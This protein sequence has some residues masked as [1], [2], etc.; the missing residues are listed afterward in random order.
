MSNLENLKAAKDR[1]ELATLLG[2]KPSAL[3]SII[4]KTPVADKYTTFEIQKK[5]GGIRV[6][7]APNDRLKMLQ[8]RLSDLL[9]KCLAEIEEGRSA[10]PVS[11]GFRKGGKLT[12][13]A[14]NHKR[15]RFVLN[16]DIE[17][18]FPSFNFGRVRGF[19]LRDKS[20]ELN[21]EVATT[22]AQIACDGKAL[23]Q[24]SPC[25][26][27]ISELIGQILDLRLLRFA[28]KHGVR[29]S[30]YADDI[31]F[32]SNQ[33]IFPEALAIQ[34]QENLG[35]WT[36]GKELVDKITA[37]GFSVNDEKTRMHV[38]SSRQMVTGLVVNHKA[39]IKSEYYRNARAMC[40]SLFITGQYFRSLKP[41][42]D[43]GAELLPDMTSSLNPLEGILS[44]IYAVTQSEEGRDDSEQRQSPRAIRKLYRRFLFYK[45]FIAPTAPLIVTEGKTD[46]IYLRAA[47]RRLDKFHPLLGAQGENGF[48]FAIRF[49]NYRGQSHEIMDLGGGSADMKSILL[50]YLQNIDP[51]HKGRKPIAHKPLAHPVIMLV[52][53][54]D[55]LQHIAGPIKKMFKVEITLNSAA[56]FYHIIDNLYLVKTPEA[57]NSSCIE[58]FFPTKW[59]KIELKGKKLSLKT[60][61]DNSKH[62][63]K[64][65][66]AKSVIRPNENDIDFS[67]FEPLLSRIVAVLQDYAA[68]LA[69]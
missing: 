60:K 55:G 33:K 8:A 35:E 3:T 13:N 9:Y 47:I 45:H 24:G 4:Y 62:Y 58:D 16:L 57:G 25:S 27:V 15:R 66:F 21:E 41:G 6:I 5:S 28:K 34:H 36:L 2:Y 65:I 59:K 10:T 49:F 17:D 56:P 7:K 54:D 52:D 69:G 30:R 51:E 14:K 18:F 48:Q 53:N 67:G 39:N 64:E 31:T 50:D 43:D 12:D 42:D 68:R 44:H 19:F 40:D 37:C 26:P 11:Y 63:G 32:S 23:P 22:I 29:Y 38:R 1:K 61:Y 20:F 46:P